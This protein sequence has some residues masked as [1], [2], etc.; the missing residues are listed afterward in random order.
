MGRK[1]HPQCFKCGVC[2]LPICDSVF[3]VKDDAVPYHPGCYTK[4]RDHVY[5][6]RAFDTSKDPSWAGPVK[7]EMGRRVAG[8]RRRILRK[9]VA[10]A[11]NS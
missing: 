7:Q 4:R 5:R 8:G 2:N 9:G 3:N 6:G 11:E 10:K 1:W